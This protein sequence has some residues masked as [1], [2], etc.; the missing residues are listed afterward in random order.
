VEGAASAVGSPVRVYLDHKDYA[1]ITKGLRGDRSH[2]RDV[3]HYRTLQHLITQGRVVCPFSAIHVVEAIRSSDD[4]W[5]KDYSQV[6]DG[7]TN[8]KCLV[9]RDQLQRR[10]LAHFVASQFGTP[11]PDMPSDLACGRGFEAFFDP[12]PAIS[13]MLEEFSA[14]TRRAVSELASEYRLNRQQRRHFAAVEAQLLSKVVIP[15]DAEAPRLP[16]QVVEIF[17]TPRFASRLLTAP[18]EERRR[19]VRQLMDRAMTFSSIL[20]FYKALCPDFGQIGVAFD[21]PAQVVQSAIRLHRVSH[22]ALS[23]FGHSV[24]FSGALKRLVELTAHH[25]ATTTLTPELR[26]RSEEI[27]RALIEHTSAVSRPGRQRC[28]YT[29]STSPGIQVTAPE[30]SRKAICATSC[31]LVMRHMLTTWLPT[32][33]S[34]R[35]LQQRSPA[36]FRIRSSCETSANCAIGCLAPKPSDDSPPRYVEKQRRRPRGAEMRPRGRAKEASRP[37]GKGGVR[38]SRMN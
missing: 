1:N 24:D 2:Q 6:V 28:S 3:E 15:S 8:G 18:R 11:P 29:C 12:E 34:L 17:R 5:L 32:G 13:A 10:E 4:D 30:Q 25:L 7:L 21:E 22:R 31:T 14:A 20:P 27:E 9:F 37:T 26:V 23:S 19:L 33:T 38:R 35:R 36:G 16:P